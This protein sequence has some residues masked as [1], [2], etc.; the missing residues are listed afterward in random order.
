MFR[1]STLIVSGLIASVAGVASAGALDLASWV[2]VP[3]SSANTGSGSMTGMEFTPEVDVVVKQ[4]G[5]YDD[6]FASADGL[7]APHAVGIWDVQSQQLLAMVTVPAAT[8]A[9]R[10]GAFRFVTLASPV[11]I[12]EG[13]RCVVAGL[14]TGD[15]TRNVTPD[16]SLYIDSYIA[17]GPWRTGSTAFSFPG[18]VLDVPTRRVGPAFIFEPAT[19]PDPG[20]PAWTLTPPQEANGNSGLNGTEFTPTVDVDVVALAYYD[21]RF[22]SDA[23][24]S[25]MHRV[26][27]FDVAT[28]TLQVGAVVPPGTAAPYQNY[29]YRHPVLPTRLAAG[30]AY[31]VAALATGDP[32]HNV[33]PGSSMFVDASL[34]LG[35]W[36]TGA[37]TF[38][39]PGTSLT[40][41]ARFMGPNFAFVTVAPPFIR[42]DL[43]C[44]GLV[45][46]FD[47]DPFVL[48]LADAVAYA[49]TYPACDIRA[50]DTN[51]DGL[52]NNFD[53]DGFVACVAN[54]GCP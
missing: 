7:A 51:S 8:A 12:D 11:A 5:W 52:I 44:D 49:A 54:L 13:R 34:T 23:G 15:P 39:F 18:S 53:I 25:T 3:G 17:L 43:N 38:G 16:S 48:A 45:N 42:A 28:E 35:P 37:S 30:T 27:I 47:I 9:P 21:D 26:G 2:V 24:L 33:S 29:F 6:T 46:N 1:R 20:T 50:A 19:A 32:G 31:V 41:S 22:V 36:R 10:N 40:T 14:S 4:L